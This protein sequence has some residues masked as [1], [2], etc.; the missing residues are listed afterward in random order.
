M[1]LVLSPTVQTELV[2]ELSQCPQ[3]TQTCFWAYNSTW[4]GIGPET[5]TFYR[6]DDVRR[7]IHE[8]DAGG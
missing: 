1:A 2:A 6:S 5:L 4:T 3:F 8:K 7:Y